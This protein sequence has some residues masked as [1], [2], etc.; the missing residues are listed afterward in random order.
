[1]YKAVFIIS[2]SH[3]PK[4]YKIVQTRPQTVLFLNLS[5]PF[6]LKDFPVSLKLSRIRPSFPDDCTE[7]RSL[8]LF[9]QFPAR[10]SINFSINSA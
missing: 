5:S 6:L 7:N 8:F 9:Q 10:S 2:L 4:F 3:L 1:M